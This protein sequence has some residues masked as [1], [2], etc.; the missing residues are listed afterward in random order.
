MTTVVEF[1]QTE[2]DLFNSI[3][4]SLSDVA[5]EA[6]NSVAEMKNVVTKLDNTVS[7]LG[8]LELKL[9]NIA[10][11]LEEIEAELNTVAG[12]AGNTTDVSGIETR[13]DNIQ[14]ELATT[15]TEWNTYNTR[16]GNPDGGIYIVPNFISNRHEMEVAIPPE[17]SKAAFDSAMAGI[18]GKVDDIKDKQ[19]N[20]INY[21]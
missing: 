8:D 21:D 16:L 11:I 2:L 15:N 13:L 4:S 12:S 17:T 9:G 1:A 3:D 10:V 6:G 7:A 14:T 18:D 20:P 19:D 5:T